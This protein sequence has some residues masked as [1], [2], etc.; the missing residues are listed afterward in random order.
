MK[1]DDALSTFIIDKLKVE[2]YENREAMGSRAASA[3]IE[4]MKKLLSEQDSM[5]MIFAAAP[6]QNELLEELASVRGLDWSRVT[7]F[8]MDEYIGLRPDAPQSFGVFLTER[9]FGKVKFRKVHYISSNPG[10][11]EEECKRYSSLLAE[12]PIDIV[13]LGIGENGHIAFNDPDVADFNDPL[14][15]KIVSLDDRS[16]Q[17]Q[18]NDGCFSSIA[19]VPRQAI[20]LTIPALIS[21]RYMYAVVPGR[22]KADA[23]RRTVEGE[24]N[25]ACPA[26]ILR[27]HEN[28]TLFLDADSAAGITS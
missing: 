20:T 19:E 3:V 15:V 28:A 8:H 22:T 23:V 7:A 21:S 11:V 25:T 13:C 9:I 2:V 5:R 10:S 16:R 4:R 24:I 6:S 18:V 26:T 27:R 12:E 17:Q 1:P 14:S